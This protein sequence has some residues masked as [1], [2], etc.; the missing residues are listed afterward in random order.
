MIIPKPDQYMGSYMSKKRNSIQAI[1]KIPLIILLIITGFFFSMFFSSTTSLSLDDTKILIE[2]ITMFFGFFGICAAQ[3][4][5]FNGGRIDKLKDK[6]EKNEKQFE[7]EKELKHATKRSHTL[8]RY[9]MLTA[10]FYI[11]ALF[12]AIFLYSIQSLNIEYLTEYKN[13][14]STI[15]P[16]TIIQDP[17]I[18]RLIIPSLLSFT[19]LFLGLLTMIKLIQTTIQ[20]QCDSFKDD[21]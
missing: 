13:S 14:L 18:I 4:L 17:Y 5:I 19:F 15:G 3:L 1:L 20:E 12:C 11:T 16:N 7:I 6:K 21:L 2:T 8:K 10:I 9:I